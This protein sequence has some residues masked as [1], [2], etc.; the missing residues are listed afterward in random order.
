MPLD[1]FVIS[2]IKDELADKIM[3]AKIEKIH[4]P[5]SDEII[6]QLRNNREGYKLL[7]SSNSSFP[8]IHLTKIKKENPLT[9]PTFCMLLR[10]HLQSGRIVDIIQPDFERIIKLKIQSYDELNDLTTKYLIIELMGKHSN[11]ILVN[12]E[13]NRVLDSIKRITPDLSRVRQVLPGI[14]YKSPPSQNKANPL[15]SVSLNA[16]KEILANKSSAPLY[17]ALYMSFTGI[18]PLLARE[19]CSRSNID[20]ETPVFALS[21]DNMTNLFNSFLLITK[22][23]K[24]KNYS[25]SIYVNN[26][27]NKFVDFSFTSI[28]HMKYYDEIKI[29]SVS[30]MLEFY[31]KERDLR[32]RIKQKSG[33]FKKNISTKLDRLHQ[34]IY[35]LNKDLDKAEKAEKYKIKGDLL[36]ANLHLIKERATVISVVNYYDPEQA[37]IDIQLS[38]RLSPSKNAQKY[39]KQY[40]KFKT[41][42]IEVKKQVEK[43]YGEIEYLDQILISVESSVDS[44]DL[45]EIRQELIE[46]G[47]LK[48]KFS[49]KKIKIQKKSNYLK[50]LSSDGYEILVGKNNIQNDKITFKIATKLDLWFHIKNMPGSHVVLRIGDGSYSD[51]TLIEAASLAAYFSKAKNATKVSVDYTK[52]KNVKK[53]SGAKPGMVIYETYNTILVDGYMPSVKVL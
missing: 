45:D 36:T 37:L 31:Y 40:N 23:V 19:V 30:E 51:Q 15:D 52:R 25:P 41:A 10:K 42:K 13:D 14:D 47:Y 8:R 26:K 18:S 29:S 16:F 3:N 2:A 12:E 32:E 28:E 5:E 27:L 4:Q 38:P 9:A 48:K 1:G 22:I 21:L 35:N 24:G 39:Y 49:K 6:I 11:I 50:Y 46:T 20:S 34:K 33:D 53:Q 7:L 43:T 44:H 17:K